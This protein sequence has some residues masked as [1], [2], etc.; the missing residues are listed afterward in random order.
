M[1]LFKGLPEVLIQELP[2]SIIGRLN[3]NEDLEDSDKNVA[4]MYLDSTFT[5]P[6]MV[7]SSQ[8]ELESVVSFYLYVGARISNYT[9]R[10]FR[11]RS[12][13]LEIMERLNAYSN[14]IDRPI[15]TLLMSS[16]GQSGFRSFRIMNADKGFVSWSFYA[17][18]L[19]KLGRHMERWVKSS[20]PHLNEDL[21]YD[22]YIDKFH[23][24]KMEKGEFISLPELAVEEYITSIFGR[25]LKL[26]IDFELKESDFGD[27]DAFQMKAE[28]RQRSHIRSSSIIAAPRDYNLAVECVQMQIDKTVKQFLNKHKNETKTTSDVSV[29]VFIGRNKIGVRE[30]CSNDVGFN[31]SSKEIILRALGRDPANEKRG[32]INWL[33]NLIR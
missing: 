5:H 27:L 21:S 26:A 17:E 3:K 33:V 28:L 32:F 31:Q 20:A 8:D 29:D 15:I 18:N 25:P 9:V 14:L 10:D 19:Y 6:E 12:G 22:V 13:D 23:V 16:E 7:A 4:R 11:K 30:I 24:A 2:N 1:P